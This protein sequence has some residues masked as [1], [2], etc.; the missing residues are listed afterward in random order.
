VL[1]VTKESLKFL[2]IEFSLSLSFEPEV[3][4]I[5]FRRNLAKICVLSNLSAFFYFLF[6]NTR[7]TEGGSE[8]GGEEDK[9]S[10]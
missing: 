10:S 6:N 8:G 4:E 5:L 7:F 1:K 9:L 3:I 2:E